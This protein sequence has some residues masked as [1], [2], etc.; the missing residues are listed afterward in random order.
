VAGC[1]PKMEGVLACE[2][3]G[4]IA[5]VYIL[6]GVPFVCGCLGDE[7]AFSLHLFSEV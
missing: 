1:A 5:N 6:E 4:D 7:N 3:G 2:E